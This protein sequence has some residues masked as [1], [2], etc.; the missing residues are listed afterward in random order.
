[1]KVELLISLSKEEMAQITDLREQVWC[2]EEGLD[3]AVARDVGLTVEDKLDAKAYHFIIRNKGTMMASARLTV[4]MNLSEVPAAAV[5]RDLAIQALPPIGAFG[6][7][8]V[9]SAFRAQGVGALLD[10]ARFR[11]AKQI[12]CKT[13]ITYAHPNRVEM[14]TL[15]GFEIIGDANMSAYPGWPAELK[16]VALKCS[17]TSAP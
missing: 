14:L 17:L 10:L 8:V 7:S 11:K 4:H 1:M 9:V 5:Y 2:H 15:L 13:L 16:R 6:R 12:G 3:K